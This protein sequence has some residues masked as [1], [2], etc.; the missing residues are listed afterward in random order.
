MSGP[1]DEKRVL[2]AAKVVPFSKNISMSNVAQRKRAGL[3]FMKPGG[4]WIET[5]HC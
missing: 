2:L 1:N 5:R 3:I 4:L